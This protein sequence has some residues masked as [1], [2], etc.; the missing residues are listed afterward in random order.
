[1]KETTVRTLFATSFALLA[2]LVAS[3]CGDD[4]AET[5]GP[6]PAPATEPAG[7]GTATTV[8]E[9]TE[10]ETAGTE[11]SPPPAPTPPS[12]PKACPRTK[13]GEDGIYTNLVAVRIGTHDGYDRIT[14]EFRAPDP[15]PGG[16]GGIP[17]Y[18][19]RTAQPPHYEDPSGREIDVNGNAF[20]RIVFHGAAGYDFDGNPTYTGP[21]TVRAGFPVLVEAVEAG[22]FEATMSWVLGMRQQACW[23]VRELDNPARVAIDMPHDVLK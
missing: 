8:M 4:G 18:E 11:T 17:R 6:T 16:K 14:F 22:D 12:A 20:G 5:A 3:G 23:K 15:N 9:T 13:G 2:L 7:T 19:I 1:M 21:R 10:T